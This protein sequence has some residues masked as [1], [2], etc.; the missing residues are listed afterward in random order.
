MSNEQPKFTASSIAIRVLE[1][2]RFAHS[3]LLIAHYSLLEAA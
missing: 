1:M 3:S 2:R